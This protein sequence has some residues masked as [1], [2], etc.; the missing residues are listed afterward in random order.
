MPFQQLQVL[1]VPAVLEYEEVAV[2]ATTS[3]WS[4]RSKKSQAQH[5]FLDIIK[6]F[7]DILRVFKTNYLHPDIT[8]AVSAFGQ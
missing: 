5:S 3:R 8:E 7:D 4:R 2:E 6:M 1:A